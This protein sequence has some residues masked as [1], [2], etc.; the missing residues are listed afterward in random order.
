MQERTDLEATPEEALKDK[1]PSRKGPGKETTK[2]SRNNLTLRI[3]SFRKIKSS[4]INLPA[5]P[6]LRQQTT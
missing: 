2:A 1:P 4:Q 6:K 5:P 3:L